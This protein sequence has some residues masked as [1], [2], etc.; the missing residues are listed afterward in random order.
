MDRNIKKGKNNKIN[1]K[2]L[3]FNGIMLADIL[4]LFIVLMSIEGF[5]ERHLFVSLF[6]TAIM[7]SILI[8]FY[9]NIKIIAGYLKQLRNRVDKQKFGIPQERQEIKPGDMKTLDE[10]AE[11]CEQYIK[12]TKSKTFA[13]NLSAMIAQS[14]RFKRKKAT[15]TGS[16]LERFSDSEMSYSKFTSVIDNIEKIIIFNT[17]SLVTRLISFDE[18]EYESL[19]HR[20]YAMGSGNDEVTKSR[21]GIYNE[22]LDYAKKA[23]DINENMLIKLDALV[24]EIAKLSS[25]DVNDINNMDAIRELETLI[26]DTKLYK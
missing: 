11:A 2:L 26:Q 15:I 9:G 14:D 1:K 3:R 10:C 5:R 23:V 12:T 21:L 19:L 6:M 13:P 17:R 4:G 25:F 22:Y 16:L 18:E 8:F 24:L 20:S 7:V